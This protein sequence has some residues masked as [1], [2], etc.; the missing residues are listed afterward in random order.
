MRISEIIGSKIEESPDPLFELDKWDPEELGNWSV[1]MSRRPVMMPKVT[2]NKP[3]FVAL[4]THR[5]LKNVHFYGVGNSQGAARDDAMKQA[6]ATDRPEDPSKFRSFNADLN[7]NFTTEYLQAD[8]SPFYK[9]QREG[10]KVVL[11]QASKK[12][13]KEFGTEIMELGFKK[14]SIR[15]GTWGGMATPVFG[16]PL[17]KNEI[18]S[19][20]LIPNMR[21]TLEYVNDDEDGNSMFLMTPDTRTQGPQDKYRM[22]VPGI[23]IAATSM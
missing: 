13:F 6:L 8:S 16:F 12:F 5:R 19:Y 18:Q 20:G 14:A 11:V 7:V 17:S 21:Y 2:G 4:V 10:D 9:F 1:K 22:G 15:S 3:Q 23:T